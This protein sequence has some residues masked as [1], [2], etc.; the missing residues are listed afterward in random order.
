MQYILCSRSLEE[1]QPYVRYKF[2]LRFAQLTVLTH[3]TFVRRW[4]VKN[5]LTHSPVTF[6]RFNNTFF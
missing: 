6:Q 2:T 5:T 1:I 3:G 4:A